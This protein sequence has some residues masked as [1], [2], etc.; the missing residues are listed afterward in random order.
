MNNE[1]MS[2]TGC[3]TTTALDAKGQHWIFFRNLKYLYLPVLPNQ[4]NE[5]LL[6]LFTWALG[7]DFFSLIKMKVSFPTFLQR[8][9]G[10]YGQQSNLGRENERD[11]GTEK[12]RNLLEQPVKSQ[13]RT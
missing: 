3:L 4:S 9:L 2:H 5:W 11:R 6:P 10:G 7:G 8:P 13:R 1:E 12:D